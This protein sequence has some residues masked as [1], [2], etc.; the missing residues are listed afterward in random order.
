[1]SEF[2]T[3]EDKRT[4]DKRMA[5]LFETEAKKYLWGDMTSQPGSGGDTLKPQDLNDIVPKQGKSSGGSFLGNALGFVDDISSDIFMGKVRQP[6]DLL[7]PAARL[8]EAENK[9]IAKPLARKA[10]EQVGVNYDELPGIAQFGIESIT[11]PSSWV[12]IGLLGKGA[13]AL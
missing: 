4:Y 7:R 9:Y 3:Y 5:S 10:F 13:K 1:M 6:W 11:S 12:G 2:W 8:F